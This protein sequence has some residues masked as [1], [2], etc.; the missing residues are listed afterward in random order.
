MCT[1]FFDVAYMSYLPS[2]VDRNQIIDGNSKLQI[3]ASAAQIGGPGLGGLLVEVFTAPYAVLIDA[4]SYLGSALFLVRI[5]AR[6]VSGRSHRRRATGLWV[7]LKEGLRFVL[8]NPNLRAQAGCTA[9]SNFFSN[10]TFAIY[11]VFTVRVLGLS[12]GVIGL[13]LSIG[14]IGSLVGAVTAMRIARRF[15]I[16]PTTIVAAALCRPD[17]PAPCRRTDRRC[18][19]PVSDRRH[20]VVRLLGRRLQHRPGQLPAG[21]LP[22]EAPGADELRDALHRVGNDPARRP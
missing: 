6:G 11:L 9:T 3:S 17:H 12:P 13:T 20:H 8:R 14:S 5:K 4:L 21:D 2:L 1:V 16:G 19:D 10:V 15:G 22:A 18:S 7:E